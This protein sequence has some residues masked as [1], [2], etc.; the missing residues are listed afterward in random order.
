MLAEGFR[1]S[2]RHIKQDALVKS[3]LDRALTARLA[4]KMLI[5]HHVKLRVD[6]PNYIG[7]ICMSFSPKEFVQATAESLQKLFLSTYGRAPEVK[8]QGHIDSRFPYMT[9]GLNYIVREILKNA[10]RATVDYHRNLKGK[11]PEIVVTVS[12]TK[13]DLIIRVTD[14][15]GGMTRSL[16]NKIFDYHF[17]SNSSSDV[18]ND[19]NNQISGYG[20]GIPTARA[21]CEYLNGS[22][23]IETLHGV[24][25]DVYIRLGLLTSDNQILRL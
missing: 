24:G 17:T 14:R 22:L 4:I 13:D 15:A 23:T 7:A 12:V 5:E 1:E 18:D 9:V 11:L 6:R 25:T 10:F 16:L 20:F 8:I 3:F 19:R 2:R 21:F